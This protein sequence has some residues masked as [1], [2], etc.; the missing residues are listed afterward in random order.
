MRRR[1]SMISELA[2][3]SPISLYRLDEFG[4]TYGP[5]TSPWKQTPSTIKPHEPYSPPKPETTTQE[6]WVVYPPVGGGKI[7]ATNEPQFTVDL[8]A[9]PG[10]WLRPW[11]LQPT[12]PGHRPPDG[13]VPFI[14]PGGGILVWPNGTVN[15]PA[16]GSTQAPIGST[17]PGGLLK[18]IDL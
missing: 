11:W 10:E 14:V 6:G 17:K 5:P 1:G 8:P 18:S 4:E 13:N 15:G 7:E 2:V 12:P 9:S 3:F 16:L